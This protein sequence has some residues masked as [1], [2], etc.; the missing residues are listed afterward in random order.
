MDIINRRITPDM[1]NK[2]AVV[3]I[4]FLFLFPSIVV[5]S[6]GTRENKIS[7]NNYYKESNFEEAVGEYSE[8]LT[9]KADYDLYYNRGVSF[10]K[11]GQYDKSYSDFEDAATYAN[12][13]GDQ[14]KAV[15]NAGNSNFMMAE[16]VKNENPGEALEYYGKSVQ[17]FERVLELNEDN[18]DAAYNLE[19]ARIRLD[20]IEQQKSEDQ[21]D[22]EENF[23]NQ[24]EGDTQENED[25]DKQEQN[26]QDSSQ[27]NGEEQEQEQE[28]GQEQ[29]QEDQNNTENFQSSYLS[30]DI[31]PEDIIEEEARR[32]EAAQIII[33]S[34]S[35]EPVDK[36][37]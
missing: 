19:L 25:G 35:G 2:T 23:E 32:Q 4:L 3:L 34:G 36:D 6:N 24:Q 8:G 5:F 14:I 21:Q 18:Q 20:E 26:Q 37:W 11:L 12:S 1:F 29:K 30:E 16:S 7:G 31:S 15:Y 9:K 22:G 28:Q 10:Y 17:H 33:S 27:Q 13:K